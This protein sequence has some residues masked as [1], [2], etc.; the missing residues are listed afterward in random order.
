MTVKRL[1]SLSTTKP[2]AREL[3]DS[4]KW[5][6]EAKPKHGSGRAG[7]DFISKLKTV[8]HSLPKVP[9]LRPSYLGKTGSGI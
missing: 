6:Y 4:G 2:I 7:F 8:N 1:K 9:L 5:T 3:P